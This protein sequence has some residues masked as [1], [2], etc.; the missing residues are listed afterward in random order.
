MRKLGHFQSENAEMFIPTKFRRY[1]KRA[2]N[3][4]AKWQNTVV[5]SSMQ[6]IE[7]LYRFEAHLMVSSREVGS[8]VRRMYGHSVENGKYRPIPL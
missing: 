4:N 1:Y 7:K 6:N 2:Q 8:E 5:Q 3:F